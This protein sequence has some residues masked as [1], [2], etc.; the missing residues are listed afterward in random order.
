MSTKW[1]LF[2]YLCGKAVGGLR[3]CWIAEVFEKLSDI[4]TVS[5]A[6]LASILGDAGGQTDVLLCPLRYAGVWTGSEEAP[7]V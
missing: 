7:D 2:E 4:G 5:R 6:V 3:D 1:Q